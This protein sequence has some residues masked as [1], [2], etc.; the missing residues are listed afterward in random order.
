MSTT[1]TRPRTPMT[2]V[3]KAAL[4]SG[5]AYI[6][7]F[8]FSIPVPFGLWKDVL[9]EPNWI[10]GAGS[11]A[12]VPLGAIFE[13]LVGLTG[14]VTA[15]AVYSVLRRRSQW[16]AL[17]F[18]AS[19]VIEAAV[20]FTGVF[21]VMAAYTLRTDVSGTAGADDASLLHIGQA[22][23]AVK[24]WTFL[25]GPGVMPAFN[26]LCFATVLYQSRLVPRIIPTI[27]LIGAPLLLISA[28]ST[29]FG[30]WEQTS[31]TAA[32]LTVPIALWELAIGVYMTVKGFRTD[33][34]IDGAIDGAIDETDAYRA[35]AT[36]EPVGV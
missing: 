36:L 22:L 17:G 11:D 33:E 19:R 5:I 31:S 7:T 12:G 9:D 14:V 20:I 1:M 16:G 25:Y 15:V 24:D 3:R 30:G 6:A 8:A 34:T 10:L 4:V 27:G 13:L 32:L 28:V 23:V 26:A 35:V 18:V 29:T 21:A 2:P